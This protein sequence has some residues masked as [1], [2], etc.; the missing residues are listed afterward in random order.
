MDKWGRLTG[1][2]GGNRTT[3]VSVASKKMRNLK[4]ANLQSENSH[5]WKYLQ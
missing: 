3:L 1:G 4:T 2:G 5:D